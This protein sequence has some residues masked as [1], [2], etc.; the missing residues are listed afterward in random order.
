MAGLPPRTEVQLGGMISAIKFSH[1]KNPRQGSTLTKYAMFDLEDLEGVIRCIIWPE[2]FSKF[3]QMVQPDAIVALRG[4][5]DRRPGQRGSECDRQRTDSAIRNFPAGRPREFWSAFS[6]IHTARRHWK[7][8]MKSWKKN[9]GNC[10]LQLLL[11]LADG[12]RQYAT[13]SLRVEHNAALRQQI[14]QLLGPGNVKILSLGPTSSPR[15]LRAMANRTG[16]RPSWRKAG[17]P[18]M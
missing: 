11:C 1:V 17:L 5:V 4:S 12:V 13:S 7:S 15:R 10:E 9:P 2:E 8:C 14:D 16:G 18:A 6:K 3:G